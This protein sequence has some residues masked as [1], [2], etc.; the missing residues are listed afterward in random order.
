[1]DLALLIIAAKAFL[2]DKPVQPISRKQRV[3]VVKAREAGIPEWIAFK[4]E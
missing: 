1:M 2:E 4:L 3:A